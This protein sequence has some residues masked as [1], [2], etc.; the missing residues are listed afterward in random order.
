MATGDDILKGASRLF[1]K[2][3]DR[4]KQASKQ[5]TGIGL[6]TAR[7]ALTRATF[8]PGETI[9][10]TITLTLPEPIDGKRLVVG[11]RAGQRAPLEGRLTIYKFE[12]ELDG[13]RRYET[14]EIKFELLL[15]A[16]AANV[17]AGPVEWQVWTTLEIAW[18]RN[19][20]HAV[21][22]IVTR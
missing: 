20:D 4:V 7:I 15:P 17:P 10:G 8:A 18:S 22:V 13:P 12:Q 16:E 3:G 14:G 5:V 19:L 6:G 2:V 9:A 21:D 11:I 1:A